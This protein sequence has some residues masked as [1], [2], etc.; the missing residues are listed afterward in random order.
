MAR[1]YGA[2]TYH[3]DSVKNVISWARKNQESS[4]LMNIK[5]VH[6]DALK[7]I[8]RE[9]KRGRQYDFIV[10]DPPTWGIGVKGEK[11][12]IEDRIDELL[13]LAS[14]LLA[15]RGSLILNTYSSKINFATLVELASIHFPHNKNSLFELFMKS[16]TEKH[17]YCGNLLRVTKS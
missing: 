4:M 12:K 3:V 17:L 2:E 16:K 10:M 14:S 15:H 13:Y 1:N 5:W 7:F 6:E 9:I 11:W 8:Q